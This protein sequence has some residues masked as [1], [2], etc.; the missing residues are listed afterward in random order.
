MRTARKVTTAATR[1]RSEWAASASIPR[2]PLISPTIN[3]STVRKMAARIEFPAA[4]FF[5][6]SAK[7]VGNEESADIGRLLLGYLRIAAEDNQGTRGARH[8]YQDCLRS[9]LRAF[10]CSFTYSGFQR[11]GMVCPGAMKQTR[12]R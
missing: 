10:F 2:L 8:P 1:S 4:A 3:L 12:P 7:P 6:L 9:H 5:S 11:L